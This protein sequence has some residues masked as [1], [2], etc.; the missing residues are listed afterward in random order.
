MV[1]SDTVQAATLA[2]S[3]GV[4]HKGGVKRLRDFEGIVA[5]LSEREI[6]EMQAA[7][8]ERREA[9]ERSS[10]T[11]TAAARPRPEDPAGALQKAP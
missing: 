3:V 6:D 10:D 4:C 2:F 7:I 1:R 9:R 8:D 11:H 5:F